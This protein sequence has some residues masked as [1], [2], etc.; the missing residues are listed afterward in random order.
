MTPTPEHFVCTE[1]QGGIGTL[2]LNRPPVNVLHLPM[3]HQLETAL[4]Q[5]AQDEDIH[6]LILQAEGKL[7]SAGVDV[8]DHTPDKVEEMIPLFDRVCC[9]LAEFPV[10]TLAAVQGHALGGGC[11][12]V[13]CCD[14]A[15]IA[16]NAK[17]GQP[18]IQLAA[19]APIAALRLP[20]LTGYRAAG[21]LM[22]TGRNLTAAEALEMGLVNAVLPT[23]QVRDWIQEKAAAI[24]GMSRAA[25]LLLKKSLLL[26]YGN[27]ASSLAEVERIYLRELMATNDTREGLAA[28]ME[29]RKPAWSHQ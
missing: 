10:P 17:I 7:F 18:E 11:E 29:K 5:L 14:L 19:F 23:E 15:A 4:E 27:W 6:A 26:G 2:T 22:F 25:M 16:E 8:A 12:L 28:F 24:A 1:I 21:D 9:A 20:Y 13:L 3:L